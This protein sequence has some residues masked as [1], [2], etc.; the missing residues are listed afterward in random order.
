MKKKGAFFAAVCLLI[1]LSCGGVWLFVDGVTRQ[2]WDSSIGTISENTHQGA[3]ALNIQFEMDFEALERVWEYIEDFGNPEN[4]LKL[5]QK[6]E[7]D[8]TLY[9]C[10][11]PDGQNGGG[12]DRIIGEFFREN[13]KKRGLIDAHISSVTG[14]N[15]FNIFV[16]GDF[17]DGKSGYL[18]KEYQTKKISDQFTLSFYENT[19]FSY[20]VNRGGLIM[21]RP[22]HKNSNQTMQNLFD[23]MSEEENDIRQMDAFKKNVH[24]LK[25]GW[26]SFFCGETEMFFCYEPLRTDSGWLLVSVVP[27]SVILVQASGVLKRTLIFSGVVIGIILMLVAVFYGM[28]MHEHEIH[29]REIQEALDVADMA[30]RA[31]GRFLMDIS[32]DIHTPLNA[33]LGMTAVARQNVADC[34]KTEDCLKKIEESGIQLLSLVNDVMD[35][36]QIEQ[37]TLALKEETVRLSQVF[38]ETAELMCKKGK[39]TGLLMEC[40]PIRLRDETVTGDSRRIRQILL[41]VIDNAVKYTPAGG[42][43]SLEFTQEESY[44]EGYG[45]YRFRCEDTGIGMEPEFLSRVFLPF[46]RARNTTASKIS[47]TGVGLAITKS[48]LDEMGGHIRVK[49]VPQKGS[50]FVI[51]FYLKIRKGSLET[52][53][54]AES[55]QR[56]G[57]E[58]PGYGEKRI[59]LVEDN[60]L[61]MEI[62][63]ELL[64]VTGVEVEKAA[65]GKEAVEMVRDSAA[66]YYGLIFMDIQMPVMDG[67][68]ATRQIR[69]MD[70]EDAETIPI[71]AVSANH[72]DEDVKKSLDS[73][74]NGHIAKPVD[75]DSIEKVLKKVFAEQGDS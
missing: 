19:G 45:V 16:K 28:K 11:E 43:V 29:T 25:T 69:K 34:A 70:R 27:E 51:E 8:I 39:E 63:E 6:A 57:E 24:D 17:A 5:Y 2:L 14:E 30:N 12:Q 59:L 20:L 10:E 75:F 54:A 13:T 15:V 58:S 23:L 41:N 26:A 1:L 21:V 22:G 52:A 3:N 36:S 40:A 73:G 68:E 53:G 35:M 4:A 74:M 56:E 60:E 72:L 61:N 9:I 62:M 66:G 64:S 31:K 50:V 44:E 38:E 67:Y 71:F 65:D 48:L 46:E 37:G 33:I 7:P 49:S 18:V 47:G 42:R 32:H 55:G